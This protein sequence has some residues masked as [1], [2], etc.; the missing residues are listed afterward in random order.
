MEGL[1]FLRD[2]VEKRFHPNKDYGFLFGSR[3]S[4]TASRFGDI[5]LEQMGPPLSS[6]KLHDFEKEIEDSNCPYLVEIVDFNRV[7][8]EFKKVAL[9][10][11][12][13]LTKGEDQIDEN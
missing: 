12:I 3:A 8:P 9:Q 2:L 5:G 11:I 4:G 13:P 1:S 7:T 6:I 10:N